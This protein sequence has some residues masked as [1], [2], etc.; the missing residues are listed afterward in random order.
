MRKFLQISRTHC[1]RA[2]VFIE[3]DWSLNGELTNADIQSCLDAMRDLSTYESAHG[4]SFSD[5]LSFG[6][7]NHDGQIN[8]VDLTALENLLT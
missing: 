2:I 4:L 3:G 5:V 8:N 1:R 6:D 7:L